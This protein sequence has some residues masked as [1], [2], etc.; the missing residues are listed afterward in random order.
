MV[1]SPRRR[2]RLNED[3]GSVL[4]LVMIF[5]I[6]VSLVIIP[7]LSYQQTVL[8]SNSVLSAKTARLEAVKAGTRI[9]LADPA[10]LY[11][12]CGNAGPTVAV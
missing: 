9:A 6:V 2:K 3:E 12:T 5:T 4:L 10:A 11:R 8:R 7:L 1:S